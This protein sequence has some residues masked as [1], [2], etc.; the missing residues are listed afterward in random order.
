MRNTR[1]TVED[2]AIGKILQTMPVRVRSLE[3]KQ[4]DLEF[5]SDE[6]NQIQDR[7]DDMYEQAYKGYGLKPPERLPKPIVATPKEK[8]GFFSRMFGSGSTQK[9]V[10]FDQLPN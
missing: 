7:I 9:A 5:G 10:P 2:K 4:K 6:W 8:P 3:A 1:P